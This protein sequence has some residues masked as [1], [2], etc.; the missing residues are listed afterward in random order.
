MKLTNEQWEIIA[1]LLPQYKRRADG[2]GRPRAD[3]RA[4]V[5]G[6][7]WILKTGAQWKYLP[8]EY[9]PRA[10][11]HRYYREWCRDGTWRRVWEAVM[12]DLDKRGKFDW[13]EAFID[14]SFAAAKKG[15]PL[16][17][18]PSAAK[19]RSGWRWS[20]AMVCLSG[21]PPPVRRRRK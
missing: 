7:L 17:A 8:S 2:K 10:T 5:D 18:K 4:V 13:S 12:E 15:V 3:M 1:P 9:P 16:S 20:T 19:G 11:C 21:L 6:I 14:G